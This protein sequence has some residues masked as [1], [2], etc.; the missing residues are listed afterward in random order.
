LRR[1]CSRVRPAVPGRTARLPSVVR[2]IAAPY[3]TGTIRC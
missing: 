1:Q 3:F 2:V